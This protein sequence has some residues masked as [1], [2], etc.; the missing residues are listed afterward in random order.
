M[1]WNVYRAYRKMEEVKLSKLLVGNTSPDADIA[2]Y[3]SEDTDIGY[4]R[5]NTEIGKVWSAFKRLGYVITL[6]D[7]REFE[8]RNL[9]GSR[10]LYLPRNFQMSPTHLSALS[11]FVESGIHVL[12]SA[13]LPGQ[14]DEFHQFNSE[15]NHFMQT[16]FG[17]NA[18]AA[19]PGKLVGW[20]VG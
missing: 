2:I 16:L 8:N 19:Y 10:V 14:F 15:W 9:H 3:W 7:D 1:F 4:N 17:I 6:I 13:D 5:A 18:S 11:E 12:T 20:L